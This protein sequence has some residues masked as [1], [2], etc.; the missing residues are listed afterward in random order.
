MEPIKLEAT[1]V[2][3]PLVSATMDRMSSTTFLQ[4][5]GEL[6]AQQPAGKG[7]LQEASQ[8]TTCCSAH[9][10]RQISSCMGG[11]GEALEHTSCDNNHSQSCRSHKTEPFCSA[12]P[13]V[14]A[15]RREMEC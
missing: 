8:S 1:T 13:D 10:T 11:G 4:A 15:D 12:T 7:A 3:S 14:I 9:M 6:S 5:A 2:Y